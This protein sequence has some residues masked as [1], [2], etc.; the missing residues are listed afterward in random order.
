MYKNA[1]ETLA[2][3]DKTTFILV[4]RPENSPLKEAERASNEL[5][6]IGVNN[7]IMIINGVL[8]KL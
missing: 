1:V 2:D 6:E 5:Q 7:Q 3:K 4:S 8:Q